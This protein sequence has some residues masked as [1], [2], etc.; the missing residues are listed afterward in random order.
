MKPFVNGQVF[1]LQAHF[2]TLAMIAN[3]NNGGRKAAG[4]K[5]SNNAIGDNM[6]APKTGST[7]QKDTGELVNYKSVTYMACVSHSDTK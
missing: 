2:W 1:S 6:V 4:Q 7:D 3:T 5:D